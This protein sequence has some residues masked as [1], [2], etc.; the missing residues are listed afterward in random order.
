MPSHIIPNLS[1][2][3]FQDFYARYRCLVALDPKIKKSKY[4]V[5]IKDKGATGAQKMCKVRLDFSGKIGCCGIL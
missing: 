3:T 2:A 5:R 4:P 1:M